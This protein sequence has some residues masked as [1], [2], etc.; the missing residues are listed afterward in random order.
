MA[1]YSDEDTY[2]IPHNYTDNG[3]ILGIIEK[4]SVYLAL[5]WFVPMA[6]L[7]F[8]VLPFNFTAKVYIFMLLIMPPTLIALIGVGSDT[9]FNFLKYVYNYY[10]NAKVYY[11]EK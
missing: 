2:I 8:K 10:K 3:K 11:Y 9:L 4:E 5:G 7:N 1:R 6:I